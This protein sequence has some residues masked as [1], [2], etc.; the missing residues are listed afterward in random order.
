MS[1]TRLG[2]VVQVLRALGF[3]RPDGSDDV[4]QL[5]AGD[6]TLKGRLVSSSCQLV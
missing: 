4:R 6:L 3:I 1:T 2:P 5:G